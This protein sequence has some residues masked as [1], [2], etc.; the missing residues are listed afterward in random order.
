MDSARD[1]AGRLVQHA[2]RQS[3]C[4]Q[5]N[6][7][8]SLDQI[9]RDFVI[10]EFIIAKRRIRESARARS[11]IESS[12][13]FFLLQSFFVVSFLQF[14]VFSC[15]SLL[16]WSGCCSPVRTSCF[17]FVCIWPSFPFYYFRYF[18]A[19]MHFSRFFFFLPVL[20][21]VLSPLPS[22]FFVVFL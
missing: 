2:N 7:G 22:S 8:R 11:N 21:C 13:T 4:L 6:S 19:V 17:S 9:I 10:L 5:L 20:L 1:D 15:F 12:T 16:F 18:Y 3:C 14:L